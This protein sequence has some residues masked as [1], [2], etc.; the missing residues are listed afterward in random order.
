MNTKFKVLLIGCGNMAGGYDL[1]QPEEALPLGHAKAFRQHGG[2]KLTSCIDPNTAQRQAFQSRWQ[3]PHGYDLWQDLPQNVGAFDVVSICSPTGVHAKDI[4]AALALKPRLI[5]CEK[6]VTLHV[7]H[8]QQ[9]VTDCASQHVLLAV[10]HSRRW[11]PEVQ[12]LKQQ[13]TQGQWGDVRSVSAAYNKGLLNNGSHMI[14]LLLKF[15]LVY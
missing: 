13:L 10:N 1:L 7:A 4:Q 6:P 9:A 11:S 5:F 15:F 12:Y 14:D 8:T 2:F 3:V